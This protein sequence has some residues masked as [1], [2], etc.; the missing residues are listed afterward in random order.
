[1]SLEK[2]TQITVFLL[3]QRNWFRRKISSLGNAF[4]ELEISYQKEQ[5]RADMLADELCQVCCQ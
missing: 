4:E 2:H 3:K 1:M 5:A